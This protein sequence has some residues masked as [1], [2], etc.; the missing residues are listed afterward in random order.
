M[1]LVIKSGNNSI[2]RF[3][4]MASPSTKIRSQPRA[5]ASN[6]A[7]ALLQAA[8]QIGKS[9]VFIEI[10]CN[11]N[12]S[13]KLKSDGLENLSGLVKVPLPA[14]GDKQKSSDISIVDGLFSLWHPRSDAEGQRVRVTIYMGSK[15]EMLRILQETRSAVIIQKQGRKFLERVRKE[16]LRRRQFSE[17][18]GH[19]SSQVSILLF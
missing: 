19:I 14:I 5:M 15:P 10:W 17:S 16:K 8:D 6:F 12:G 9:M 2:L 1:I 7:D 13:S 4:F 3:Y 18:N 11:C